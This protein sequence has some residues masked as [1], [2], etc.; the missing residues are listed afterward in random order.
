MSTTINMNW[1]TIIINDMWIHWTNMESSSIKKITIEINWEVYDIITNNE[2]IH[3]C[4]ITVDWW[5][6]SSESFQITANN[7]HQVQTHNWWVTVQGNVSGS[8]STH[9]GGVNVHWDVTWNV[10][11]HNW[12][13]SVGGNVHGASSSTISGNN[14]NLVINL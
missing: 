8:V 11:T 5:N 4:T 7:P 1:W 3:Q 10:T 14:R 9:N 13:I 12:T 2:P 6:I